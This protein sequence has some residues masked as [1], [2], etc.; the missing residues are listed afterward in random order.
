MH[1]LLTELSF[2]QSQASRLRSDRDQWRSTAQTREMQLLAAELQVEQQERTIFLLNHQNGALR[3]EHEADAT[4]SKTLLARFRRAV[5]KQDKLVETLDEASRQLTQL[6]KSDRAKGKVWQRNL[7]LKAALHQCASRKASPSAQGQAGT[8]SA[9]Q[10]ALAMA[11]ERIEELESKGEALLEALD[12]RNDSCG[13]GEDEDMPDNGS[14]TLIEAE[15]TFRGVLE[16][17][18]FKEQKEN[19]GDLLNEK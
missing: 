14:A 7:R 1:G 8:E 16:D 17:E 19:W 4:T 2:T 3:E 10:E 12:K 6:K 15:L 11:Q 9:L 18:T 5:T 13:S